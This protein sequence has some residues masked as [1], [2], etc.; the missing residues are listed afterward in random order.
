MLFYTKF[1]AGGIVLQVFNN[2]SDLGKAFGVHQKP[3]KDKPFTCRKCGGVMRHI[4][5]T[6]I[7]LCENEIDYIGENGKPCTRV[8]GNRVL[9]KFIA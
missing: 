2:F 5:S 3:R 6:N 1:Y 4:P 7:Y 8:C 9:T